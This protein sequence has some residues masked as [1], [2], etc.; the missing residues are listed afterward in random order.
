MFPPPPPLGTAFTGYSSI[1]VLSD[2]VP[3]I[4]FL[5]T[6]LTSND[7]DSNCPYNSKPGAAAMSTWFNHAAI[8]LHPDGYG[9]LLGEVTWTC[10]RVHLPL[11]PSYILG[12]G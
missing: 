6:P 8:G 2:S 7:A 5:P 4:F 12:S 1:P 10:S 9:K 11:C 3:L